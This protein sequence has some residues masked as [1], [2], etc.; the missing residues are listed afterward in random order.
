MTTD[1]KEIRDHALA[2]AK[3][4]GFP[5]DAE[6]FA[7][8]CCLYAF[9]NPGEEFYIARRFSDYRRR[10]YGR[11]GVL[12][13][14]ARRAGTAASEA[15]DDNRHGTSVLDPYDF[16]LGARYVAKLSRYER[17]LYVLRHKYAVP[18]GQLA[19]SQGV[20]EVRIS[21]VLKGIQAAINKAI[22]LGE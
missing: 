11:A 3:R 21:Q 9:E 19:D 12:S 1:F 8:D 4:R 22:Q 5:S 17:L 2:Y 18:L 10:N 16:L 14:E 15:Y 13:S 20:S 6:D 7:Q